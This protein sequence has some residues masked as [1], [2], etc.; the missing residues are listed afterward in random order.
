MWATNNWI[1]SDWLRPGDLVCSGPAGTIRDL[2]LDWD[3]HTWRI[4]YL[5]SDGRTS[6][7]TVQPH[8]WTCI[9]G[10]P[11]E[12]KALIDERMNGRV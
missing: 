8:T 9:A 4:T 10:E 1:R 7:H 6:T 3:H 12:V 2:V 11:D 5:H